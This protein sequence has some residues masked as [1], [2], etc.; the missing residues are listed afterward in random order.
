M[1]ESERGCELVKLI[2]DDPT[3][4]P[5]PL[6]ILRNQKNLDLLLHLLDQLDEEVD[7]KHV[8]L[9]ID[10]VLA[11]QILAVTHF[12]QTV[13]Y[14]EGVL[15]KEFLLRSYKLWRPHFFRRHVV[16]P[17][18]QGR[19]HLRN[20]LVETFRKNGLCGLLNLQLFFL[21][22]LTR[23]PRQDLVSNRGGALLFDQSFSSATSYAFLPAD[24][25]QVLQ[26]LVAHFY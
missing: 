16:F 2:D 1:N 13:L 12:V 10:D 14:L 9:E 19:I 24:V 8:L 23:A 6:L 11:R 5:I 21:R 20:R 4:L 15:R 3:V 25:F 17:V 7:E 18:L 22:P 26:Q